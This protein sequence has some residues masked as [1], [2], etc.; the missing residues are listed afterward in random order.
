MT[1]FIW[2]LRAALAYRRMAALNFPMAWGCAG[3]LLENRDFFDGPVDAVRGD[4]TYWGE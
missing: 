2:R 4:L 1:N 3:A